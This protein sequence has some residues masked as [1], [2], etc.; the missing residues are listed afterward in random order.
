MATNNDD[1]KWLYGKFKAKGYNVGTEQEFTSSLTNE[2][3]RQWYYEKGKSM[4]L[5]LG[6]MDDFNTLYAPQAVQ[7]TVAPTPVQQ[8]QSQPVATAAPASAPEPAAQS[9][10]PP[11][12]AP[13]TEQKPVSG[14]TQ[15]KPSAE[16]LSLLTDEINKAKAT[17]GTYS[18]KFNNILKWHKDNTGLHVK[19]IRLGSNQNVV[20]AVPRFN[21]RTGKLEHTYITESGNEYTDRTLA[22][23]EQSASDEHKNFVKRMT[24][25]GLNP[26]S[27]ED[28]EKQAQLDYHAP[29]H[30]AVDDIWKQ[31]EQEDKIADEEYRLAIETQNKKL[32]S[33]V[34][35]MGPDGMPLPT[36]EETQRDLER[37]IKRKE[38]FNLEQMADAIY[39]ELP[40]SYKQNAQI[41]YRE[42]YA[43]HSDELNGRSIDDAVEDALKAEVY[44]AVYQR[45]VKE[46]MPKN[47]TEF[48]LRKIADQPL[49]SSHIAMGNAAASMTGS[50]GMQLAN[51]EAMGQFGRRH[52]AL[53][54][55]G[56][57]LNMA[58]DPTTYM[59]GGLGSIAGKGAMRLTGKQLL[60]GASKDAAERYAAHTL[61]GR[62]IGGVAG[63]A[64]NFAA[65]ETM[66][67][68]QNQLSVGGYINPETGE[69]EG[70][71]F[72]EVLKASGHGLI[73]GGVTG[74]LSPII[75]NVA[76]KAVHATT[77]TAGKIGVRA[78]EIAVST[79]VEGTVFSIPEWISGEGSAMDVWTDNMAMMLGFKLSH[80]IKSAPRIIAG[81]KGARD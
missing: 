38:T 34:H 28:I 22:D 18:R 2:A 50:W 55:T 37:H 13:S 65:F 16:Q 72:G 24:A 69:N 1:I 75:G 44:N 74:G 51:M 78:G 67:N 25:N 15:E 32:R 9:D 19:P 77:S 5:D 43:K 17:V 68:V 8:Q 71:S 52:R 73:L 46:Q 35:A 57:V 11:I 53:D 12:S 4:G 56:T 66:K 31:A 60:K 7:P 21:S 59:A 81:G 54:I 20:E 27:K 14:H 42:Y 3:D 61:T 63:G 40:Y 48:L 10:N 36:S 79:L 45:A 64:A 80:G 30:S 39:S 62:I 33:N 41:V 6:S 70:F 47:K 76:D 58:L 26:D 29:L 49:I 23:W